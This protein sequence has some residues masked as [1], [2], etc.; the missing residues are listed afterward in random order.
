[1]KYVK[2]N[3]FL[4]KQVLK[5]LATPEERKPNENLLRTASFKFFKTI[6]LA[7]LWKRVRLMLGL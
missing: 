3:H 1:M 7:L 6:L 4:H 5:H 2:E